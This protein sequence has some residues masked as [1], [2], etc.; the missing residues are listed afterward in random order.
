MT[1]K[2]DFYDDLAEF[3]NRLEKFDKDVSK[4]LKA[5]L[6]AGAGEVAGEA[7][8]R[9]AAVGVPLSNWAYG[10]K[11]QDR[12]DGRDLIYSIARANAQITPI[13]YRARKA[14]ATVAFGMYVVQKNPAASIFELAG[15]KNAVSKGTRGGSSSFNENVLNKYGG[16]PYP[17]ILYPSYYAGMKAAQAKIEEAVREAAWKVGL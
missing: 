15:S 5:D 8:K 11:E 3:I 14:G 2:I 4:T 10:W 7:R 13:A 17:R 1:Y 12:E 6:R 16:G 9:I